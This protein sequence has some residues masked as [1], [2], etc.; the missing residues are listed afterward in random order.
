MR[1]R[2]WLAVG[3]LLATVGCGGGDDGPKDPITIGVILPKSGA[4]G[5]FG[6]ALEHTIVVAVAEVNDKGGVN[7]HPLE[8]IVKDDG[9]DADMAKLRMDELL[10]EGVVAVIGP[11]T[12]G[13]VEKAFPAAAAAGV[14]L[15]SPTSTAPS[16]GEPTTMDMGYMF[17]NTPNDNFQGLAIAYY[18]TSKAEPPVDTVVILHETG[19]YGEGLATA[20]ETAFVAN[21]GTVTAKVPYTPNL[22]PGAE[23]DV[24][25]NL[26]ALTPAPT[27]VVLIGLDADEKLIVNKWAMGADLP[28]LKWFFT[29]GARSVGF[30]TD[31]DNKLVGSL[32]T[33]PTFPVTGDAYGVLADRYMQ[34][35]TDD[36]AA[37]TGTTNAWDAVFQIAAALV[38]QDHDFPGEAFGGEHLRDNLTAVSRGPGQIFHAGQWRDLVASINSGGDVD[39]D[40]ASGPVD[41][42]DNG[43]TIGPYEVWQISGADA[44][45]SFTQVLFLE[46]QAIEGLLTG[47]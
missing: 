46:A 22:A 41:F 11:A 18:L 43:E 2:N 29:D 12:S 47:P 20:F 24:L 36:P 13:A 16:L 10:L 7:G 44:N 21:E 3:M 39:Y 26:V 23:D 17:R 45:K 6:T 33:A 28:D 19:A 5:D 1:S 9:T 34:M 4:L 37:T 14:P 42:L 8:I 31:L 32:G 30:I 27:M 38:K 15:I 35:F 40:G 25:A